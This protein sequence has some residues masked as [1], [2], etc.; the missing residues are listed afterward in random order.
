MTIRIDEF[1]DR[2]RDLAARE[3]ECDGLFKEIRNGNG[4]KALRYFELRHSCK[5]LRNQIIKSATSAGFTRERI[6]NEIAEAK[7]RN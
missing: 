4:E 5:E 2:I 6:K 7:A 3:K 1:D